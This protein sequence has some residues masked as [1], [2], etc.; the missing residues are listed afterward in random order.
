M[1]SAL[2]RRDISA[3]W[4]G[5]RRGRE[6]IDKLIPQVREMLSENGVF[7]L[8]LIEDNI[9]FEVVS[10][11]LEAANADLKSDEKEMKYETILKRE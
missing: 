1:Q 3:A 8:L 11:I 4:A 9:I 10:Q 7:Y 2:D 6:V 5:G